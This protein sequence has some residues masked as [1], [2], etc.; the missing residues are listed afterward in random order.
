MRLLLL[1]CLSWASL[2]P[3]AEPAAA[4][5][6]PEDFFVAYGKA[7]PDLR[8]E[9]RGDA[10]GV[11]LDARV[12]SSSRPELEED[13]TRALLGWRFRPDREEGRPVAWTREIGFVFAALPAADA[14]ARLKKEMRVFYPEGKTWKGADPEIL[15][16]AAVAA[17]G[18]IKSVRVL[19]SVDPELSLAAVLA[20]L[21]RGRACEP[22]QREGKAVAG[23]LRIP[24]VLTT[25]PAAVKRVMPEYPLELRK[26]GNQGDVQVAFTVTAGGEP[27]GIRIIESAHPA[28][29]RAVVE[30]LGQWRFA[31]ATR[32]GQAVTEEFSMRLPFSLQNAP[33]SMLRLT[34]AEPYALSG[35]LRFPENLPEEFRYDQPPQVKLAQAAAYPFELLAEGVTGSATVNAVIR[36]DGRVQEARI[37]N[38]TRPEFGLA[39]RAAMEAWEFEPAR[40][41]GK[42]AWAL[43]TREIKF[44]RSGRDAP[45][46]SALRLLRV[47]K[48]GQ[49]DIPGLADL[50][51]LPLPVHQPVPLRPP[52]SRGADI[53]GTVV[54]EFFIDRDG[55]AQL[56]RALSSP[57]EGLAW[58]AV[59]AVSRWQFTPPLRGG[60][61]VDVRA[62]VPLEFHPSVAP[63]AGEP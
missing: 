35:E 3:A 15:L 8:V 42:P 55:R 4:L 48:D 38:A 1:L 2:V 49:P 34:A 47:L 46:E 10:E 27:R 30:A 39:A 14:P 52:G 17:D 28:L 62:S 58:A 45:G 22:A 19:Q 54:V 57:D 11:V 41:Q 31:P 37:L 51:A 40:K 61:P 29:E 43:I 7:E 23:L 18:E 24:L 9:L 12:L 50:D 16:E 26:S 59:T 33:L 44:E 20:A 53:G 32:R 5:R 25:L 13:V 56:P 21:R 6:Y 36:P 63:P 60:Q